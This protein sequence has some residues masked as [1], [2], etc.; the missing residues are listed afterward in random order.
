MKEQTETGPGPSASASDANA[1][2]CVFLTLSADRSVPEAGRHSRVQAGATVTARTEVEVGGTGGRRT[3]VVKC[4]R[5]AG[6]AS[7]ISKVKEVKAGKC[8]CYFSVKGLNVH[9]FSATLTLFMSTHESH[10]STHQHNNTG[11]TTTSKV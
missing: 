1:S 3:G 6:H 10:T 9:L 7:E 5:K 2:G 8:C 11:Q 4:Q